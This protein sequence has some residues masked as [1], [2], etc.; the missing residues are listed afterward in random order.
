MSAFQPTRW[1]RRPMRWPISVGRSSSARVGSY[2]PSYMK[3]VT[4]RWMHDF[5][6]GWLFLFL[7]CACAST[8]GPPPSSLPPPTERS[9]LG[10]GDTFPLEIVGEKD[11]PQQY[12]V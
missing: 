6:R 10:P 5:I 3:R 11:L 8:R 12:Q 9:V 1:E 4:H 7:V 2:K